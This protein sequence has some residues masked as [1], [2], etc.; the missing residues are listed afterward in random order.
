MK[1]VVNASPLI[2]LS[3]IDRLDLFRSLF[4]ETI[5]PEQVYNEVVVQGSGQPGAAALARAKWI[6]VLSLDIKPTVEPMLLGLDEGELA[7]LLLAQQIDP[8]WVIIDERRA[9]RVAMA[10]GLPVKGTLGI[11]LT[12][13]LADLISKES[14]LDDIVKLLDAGI[15]IGPKWQEWLQTELDKDLES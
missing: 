7:V 4:E 15:R 8:D 9:R 5:V 13:A 6:Q 11:L 1:V 2:T 14:V 3:I 10:M 12:A